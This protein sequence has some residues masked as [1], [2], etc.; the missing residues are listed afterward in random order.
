MGIECLNHQ[1]HLYRKRNDG[2]VG[3]WPD[4]VEEVGEWTWHQIFQNYW[5]SSNFYHNK[6]YKTGSGST[7]S[8]IK[9]LC[10]IWWLKKVFL[11]WSNS[12]SG[13]KVVH[14]SKYTW[15]LIL[16]YPIDQYQAVLTELSSDWM[17]CTIQ[18]YWSSSVRA[19]CFTAQTW[20]SNTFLYLPLT[21]M[22]WVIL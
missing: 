20:F 18:F 19:H 8:K 3:K 15:V 2:T 1:K 11:V 5:I 22:L 12:F 14:K 6:R 21:I 17:E 16:I 13:T 4:M 9:W 10:G 7:D